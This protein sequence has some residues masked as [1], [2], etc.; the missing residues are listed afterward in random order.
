[1]T[2]I[3]V[4]GSRSFQDYGSLKE[5]LDSILD[6]LGVNNV[7]IVSGGANGAD[8]LGERYASERGLRLIRFKADWNKYGR[9]AGMIR[10]KEMLDYACQ[11]RPLVVAFWDGESHGT[12]NMIQRAERRGVAVRIRL[13]PKSE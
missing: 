8:K 7:E 5:L 6:D 2:R 9:S 4:A 13:I 12:A 11:E 1:M 10:N 3:I